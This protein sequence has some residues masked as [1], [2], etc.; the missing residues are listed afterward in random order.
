MTDFLI[1][2]IYRLRAKIITHKWEHSPPYLDPFRRSILWFLEKIIDLAEYPET[3][4]MKKRA[5]EEMRK[6]DQIKNEIE[7]IRKKLDKAK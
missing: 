5:K 4:A 1:E 3:R 6:L 7:A 2:R